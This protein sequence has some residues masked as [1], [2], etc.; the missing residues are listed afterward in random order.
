MPQQ[1][2]LQSI[3]NQDF[4]ITLDGNLFGI[5]LHTT[6][7][8]MS[9]SMTIN[10]IDTLDNIRTVA[11]SPLIPSKYEEAGNFMFVTQNQALPD[12]DQFGTSQILL[13]FT[14][15]EL[16]A[17]RAPVNVYVVEGS[18]DTPTP[19]SPT[20]PTVTASYFNPLAALPLR[21]APQGYRQVT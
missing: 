2:P 7:G 13:Y 8:V 18:G 11:G 14:A 15:A 20:I 19:S 21:F 10:G 5:G 1:V 9:V 17:Y 12:Y 4:T 3:P 16:A 6:N